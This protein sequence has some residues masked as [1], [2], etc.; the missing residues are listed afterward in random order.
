[1]LSLPP[2]AGVNEKY[3]GV[4]LVV[5]PDP[6]E[7][8]EHLLS[9]LYSP[10]G[11]SLRPKDPDNP[12]HVVG[13]TRLA[14]KYEIEVLRDAIFQQIAADWPE[15][16][17][18][19][20]ARIAEEKLCQEAL[21]LDH[22]S[23]DKDTLDEIFPEPAAAINFGLEFGV[24]SMLPAA[25]YRLATIPAHQDWDVY[26][27]M[28]HPN[29]GDHWSDLY[30]GLRTAHW[31]SLSSQV[32]MHLI[33]LREELKGQTREIISTFSLLHD[34]CAKR[35][36]CK[37]TKAELLK[38][39]LSSPSESRFSDPMTVLKRLLDQTENWE[40]C[41]LC[42]WFT[43]DKLLLVRQ[44]VWSTVVKTVVPESS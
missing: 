31:G 8:V 9:V 36:S 32:L 26:R 20:D 7:A 15:D 12:I 25:F 10:A 16:L 1:M 11:L 19:W 18:S 4:P 38:N 40:I 3:D 35:V 30:D 6:A 43:R 5:F 21:S 29:Y 39:Y 34:K 17:A 23:Y 22:E 44:G 14:I 42:K 28:D 27:N 24:H 13:L 41:R 2:A 33:L 37:K